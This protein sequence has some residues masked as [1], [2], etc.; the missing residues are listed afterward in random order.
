MF[1]WTGFLAEKVIITVVDVHSARLW[2][3][4]QIDPIDE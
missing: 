2:K 4:G 3:D 1:C